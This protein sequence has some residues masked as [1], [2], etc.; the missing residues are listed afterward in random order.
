[1]EVSENDSVLFSG[2]SAGDW[3][4]AICG[5]NWSSVNIL[6]NG[7]VEFIG[8]K[9]S[10]SGGAIYGSSGSA[11]NIAGNSSVLFEKN[12]V[13]SYYGSYNLRSIY[14]GGSLSLSAPDSGEIRFH[15]TIY[16]GKDLNLNSSY[17]D[18][19]GNTRSAGGDI[20]F[21]GQYAES[22]LTELNGYTPSSSEVTSSRTS[23]VNGSTYLY[24]GTLQ[25]KGGACLKGYG[26]SATGG[27]VY[28][29]NA[30]LNQNSY[31]ASFA[32]G[33]TLS[34]GSGS[35]M[36]ASTLYLN[37][38]STLEFDLSSGYSDAYFTLS[39]DLS[40]GG[41]LTLNF[42]NT[43]YLDESNY[44]LMYVS[45]SRS[46]WYTYDITLTG[47]AASVD[48]L[49]WVDGY[50]ILN[51]KGGNLE[52]TSQLTGSVDLRRYTS[53]TF[54]DSSNYSQGAAIYSSSSYNDITLSDNDSLVF[55][56]NSVSA[57]GYYSNSSYG[58]AI[59]KSGGSVNIYDNGTVSFSG[60]S[61][62]S[63]SEY[64]SASSYGGAIYKSGGSVNIH[65]NGTVT[66]SGNAVSSAAG[67][68][69]AYSYGGAIYSTGSLDI[70]SNGSVSFSGNSVSADAG[71][72]SDYSYTAGAYGGAIYGTSSIEMDSNTSVSFTNNSAQADGED[73]ATARGGAI[74]GN[75]GIS[76][77]NNGTVTFSGNKV[78]ALH[79]PDGQTAQ[80]GAIYSSGALSIRNNTSVLFEKNVE[81]TESGYQLRGVYVADD[82]G[83]VSLSAASGNSI[84]FRD[85]VYIGSGNT[86]EL[87]NTYTDANGVSCSQTG[88]IIF[89]GAYVDSN[90]YTAK[91]YEYGT[92]EEVLN[93]KTSHVNAMTTLYGGRLRVEDGAVYMGQGITAVAGSSS[94]V[95]VKDAELRHR[96]N[97][98]TFNYGTTLELKGSCTLS[99]HVNMLSGSQ[100]S[101]GDTDL[102]DVTF[103]H[104]D[105]SFNETL[106]VSLSNVE[107]QQNNILL[108]V[109]GD[110]EGWEDTVITLPS[111]GYSVG[112]LTW[113]KNCLVLNYN[114]DTFPSYVNGDK[115]YTERLTD[116][117]SHH[118][119]NHIWFDYNQTVDALGGAIYA[120]EVPVSLA[121][122]GKVEFSSNTVKNKTAAQGGAIYGSLISLRH[123]DEVIF[124]GNTVTSTTLGVYGVHHGDGGA[125]YGSGTVSDNA[126]VLFTQN[127]A[128]SEDDSRGGAVF[129]AGSISLSG[130]ESIEFS[131]NKVTS[132]SSSYGGAIYAGYEDT[133]SITDNTRVLFSMNSTA[134]SATVDTEE[135]L[136]GAIYING[137]HLEIRNNDTVVFVKNAERM[138]NRHYLRSLYVNGGSVSLSAAEGKSIMFRDAIYVGGVE[139]FAL[140]QEYNGNAQDGDIIFSG[141][142]TVADLKEMKNGLDASS[143]EI[144][145]SRT[146]EVYAMTNLYGGRLIVEDGAV[147]ECAGIT[148]IVDTGATVMLRNGSLVRTD[149]LLTSQFT[150]HRGTGLSFVG[151]NQISAELLTMMDGSSWTF[152][153]STE[154]AAKPMLTYS[155]LLAQRGK[156]NIQINAT[157]TLTL[158]DYKLLQ[159]SESVGNWWSAEDIV[160]NGGSLTLND[161]QWVDN[162]LYF[163]YTG[164]SIS[165]STVGPNTPVSPNTPNTP[166]NPDFLKP[167]KPSGAVL[168]AGSVD[169][170]TEIQLT[171]KGSMT[172][173]GKVTPGAITVNTAQ[174]LTL[175]SNKKAPGSIAGEGDLVKNGQGTLTMNDGNTGWTG[176]VYLNAG[177][178]K[179]KGTSSLGKGD[180]YL[181][182]GILNLGS[183]AVSNDI[184]QS[185]NAAIKSGKKFAG[186]YTLETGELQKGSVLNM[187]GGKTATL[188]GGT[189]NGTISGN[190][191]VNVTGTVK[192]GATGK[193]TT[194]ALTLGANATLTT[195]AKG[196]SSKNTDI[197]VGENA[198]LNLVGKVSADSLSCTSGTL[199]ATAPLALKGNLSASDSA[200]VCSGKVSA[201]NLSMTGTEF[202]LVASAPQSIALKGNATLTDSTLT[203]NG[204]MSASNLTLNNSALSLTAS[205]PQNLTVKQNLTVNTG[206][207]LTLNGKLSAGSLTLKSGSTL[208]LTGSKPQTVK[209]KGTLTINSGSCIDLNYS[210]DKGK[211][212]K[213]L[214]FGSYSGSQDFYSLFGVSASDCLLVN[215]GKALTLTVTGNWNP[216][217]ATTASLA[218][219]DE[220]AE[221]VYAGEETKEEG[222]K[223]ENN[224]PV[225][226]MPDNRPL[227]DALV[228]ANWGQ[229]EASRAFVN[230][231]ANR[232]MAVQLG[233]GERAVWASAIGA[234]TRYSGANGHHGSDANVSGGAFGLET[235]V[236]S[237]SLFG[238]ALGNSWTRVSAHGFGTIEQDTTH[239]GVYGQSNWTSG[240]SADWSAAYGRSESECMGS[241]WNQ[242]HL[243]LDG[244][245][246]YNHELSAGTL[247]RPFAG[248]QYYTSDSATIGSADAGSLQNLRTEIGVGASHREGKLGVYGELAV[249][250]DAAR[251]NPDV[252]MNGKRYTGM[253]PGRAGLNFS[254]GASYDLSDDW[255]VNASYTGEFVEN[256][257]AHSANVGATY[258]F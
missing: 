145:F 108:Y 153:L 10:G 227:A 37:S 154:N 181:K 146:S 225:L 56:N 13:G 134:S 194:S 243:Q 149:N 174:S 199:K 141:A 121:L 114:K 162:T 110:V 92:A 45:G 230:A 186:T 76:L 93:S 217:F 177:T 125:I 254:V 185:G 147:Y 101:F 97:D 53:V 28:I 203:A 183:K 207:S 202:K 47:I 253:N 107:N 30:T 59:Y 228:Q 72:Y 90:L 144:S 6:N 133:I 67:N 120:P 69:S 57:S 40:I 211:T 111:M 180:V 8:N 105:I 85:S 161:L 237:A 155:G 131:R 55:R 64:Y 257:N 51:Y 7:E 163:H 80:G 79:A 128:Q 235:Q 184:V 142:T 239:L 242:K 102:T 63:S 219:E 182:G 201:A 78:S 190:G 250:Y 81:K 99:G 104:G 170:N 33:T 115:K 20:I 62:T 224:T 23:T 17:T 214:T 176:N 60:N 4:G 169:K 138:D 200:V 106:T 178:I 249:H 135:T 240:I 258:K 87:N 66:F 83:T 19:D 223:V 61:A 173:Q 39:G 26:F 213:L 15:D 38:G 158:G 160:V 252:E 46:G 236:G 124:R 151:V 95:S 209:V 113:V 130:N 196:L 167:Y 197:S 48:D 251:N 54:R 52:Y 117:I 148:A 152:N 232:S 132:A 18:A 126:S 118:F 73:E 247:L 116:A 89:T 112:N 84:E 179:V 248:V 27:K 165:G 168:S 136:G 256:A 86:V 29:G 50:L 82:A 14:T 175:K 36:T 16:V 210:F 119:Y 164:Q 3:G 65:D 24:G 156:L 143:E 123:N 195:G 215:T 2:N 43:S 44:K 35:K 218:M 75:Y 122:N 70:S 171:G 22:H 71:Y 231:M 220:L 246:S 159:V 139:E 25:L 150:F 129:V 32:S 244:R 21:D 212:Y 222:S 58:G 216:Q 172:L 5:T 9:A 245:M 192:L 234:S 103:L 221:A 137:G 68:D 88:D 41:S 193:I 204:K 238:L 42:L 206:S 49:S 241:D 94:T 208:T 98:L 189:V 74:W 96:D 109:T 11:I 100:L 34:V 233:N 31:S 12:A 229:L 1:M 205:K 226:T 198:S 77:V 91:G 166:I 188:K 191:K 140:N 187:N 127:E 157:E 255:S